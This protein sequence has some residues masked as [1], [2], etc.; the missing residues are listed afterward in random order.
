MNI[1]ESN[2]LAAYE[3]ANDETKN[4]LR[5]LFPE[6]LARPAVDNRPVTE[7]IKTFEDAIAALGE[8]HLFVRMFR[9]I[10][11]KSEIAGA[12]VNDDVVTY[13]KLRVIAAALNEGWEPQFTEDEF[14]YYPYFFLYTQ[15]ELDE[16]SD[17]WKQAHKV[18]PLDGVLFGGCAYGGAAAGFA[19][20]YSLSAPSSTSAIFG[21]RLCFKSRELAVYA[22]N[23][24]ADLYLHFLIK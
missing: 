13:L 3:A 15:E 14:R 18:L 5:A 11:E 6:Q 20:A 21:S 17:E 1:E 22:G 4:V 23:Q 7:C 12:N 10:Y 24:F 16:K 2:I 8:D 19:A 9:D